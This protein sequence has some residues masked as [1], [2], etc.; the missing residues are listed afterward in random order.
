MQNWQHSQA[1]AGTHAFLPLDGLTGCMH[2]SKRAAGDSKAFA[3]DNKVMDK[4][5]GRRAALL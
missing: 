3:G 1:S 2:K 4:E 5:G